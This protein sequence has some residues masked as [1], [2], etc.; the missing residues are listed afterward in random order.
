M[1][2]TLNG[3]PEDLP[4][5]LT[6]TELLRS[7]GRDPDTPGVAVAVNLEVLASQDWSTVLVRDGDRVDVVVA[8]GG[9]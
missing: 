7:L 3:E 4:A 8:V 5:P 9:G 6:V 2:I 1:N